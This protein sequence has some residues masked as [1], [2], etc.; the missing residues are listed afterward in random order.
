MQ[1]SALVRDAHLDV[2]LCG[3]RAMG[4]RN[5]HTACVSVRRQ[6]STAARHQLLS[7]IDPLLRQLKNMSI[8]KC[9]CSSL[10]H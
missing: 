3:L 10:S 7:E 4:Q 8:L 2:L 9:S 6:K 5:I 1:M